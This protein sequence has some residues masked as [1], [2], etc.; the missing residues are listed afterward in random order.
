MRKLTL[1]LLALCALASPAAAQ[2]AVVDSLQ[3]RVLGAPA[4]VDFAGPSVGYVGDTLTYEYVIRDD[5]GDPS[6]GLTTW[7]SSDT[8]VGQIVESTDSTVTVALVGRGN[9]FL[10]VTV[11]R[12][13]SLVIVGVYGPG[14]VKP[15]GTVEY[16]D[17][18]MK[19]GGTMVGCAFLYVGDQPKYGSTHDACRGIAPGPVGSPGFFLA[20]AV[21][22]DP[23]V[24]RMLTGALPGS[25]KE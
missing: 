2:Q 19:V 18:Q 24:D 9:F 8:N 3:I 17:W 12:V 16:G 15:T 20:A 25:L 11:E 6:A 5:L 23:R 22:P 4:T 7:E 21:V 1:L 10:R 14:N 13:D